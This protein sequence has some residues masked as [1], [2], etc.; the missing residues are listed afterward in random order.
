MGA[1]PEDLQAG[2]ALSP[3]FWDEELQPLVI[4]SGIEPF[5]PHS[6]LYVVGEEDLVPLS[7]TDTLDYPGFASL[8]A[9]VTDD[10]SLQVFTGVSS[11][12]LALLQA[13][14]TLRLIL[15]WL[16]THL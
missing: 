2:I 1:F 14:E 4:G 13:P 8:L 16:Q 7:D 9:S 15:D 12:G 3:G 11:H 6:I 10:P 5:K